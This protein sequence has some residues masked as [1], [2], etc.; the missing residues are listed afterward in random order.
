MV[1]VVLMYLEYQHNHLHKFTLKLQ[2]LAAENTLKTSLA[3][4]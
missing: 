2:G 3:F 4:A 1:E